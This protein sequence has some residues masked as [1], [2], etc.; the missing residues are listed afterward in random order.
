MTGPGHFLDRTDAVGVALR[1]LVLTR[2]DLRLVE[3]P[4]YL[5]TD[6]T[7]PQRRVGLVSGGG[8]GHEPMHG[9]FVGEGGLDAAA[10]GLVFASPHNS[11]VLEASRAA[12]REAGVLQIVKN[13]T[14]DVINFGI[15]AERLRA[16]GVPVARVL[17]ADD[18]ASGGADTE[19][20]R[21]GTGA[22]VIVERA[23]ATAADRGDGLDELAELG[24]RVVAASRSLAVASRAQTSLSTGAP[25]FDLEDGHL[26]YGVGIHGERAATST[27]A[28]PL[29]DL[30]SRMT[31][32][33]SDA[34]R[35]TAAPDGWSLFVNGLGS[36]IELEL[37]TVLEMAVA[38]LAERGVTVTATLVGTYVAAL[39]MRGFSLTLTALDSG[40]HEL[41]TTGGGGSGLPVLTPVTTSAIESGEPT[42]AGARTAPADDPFLVAI[43]HEAERLHGGLTRLDQLAGDGDFGDNLLAG[44]RGAA[45]QAPA[46]DSPLP[47]LSAAVVEFLD[48]VG[49]SS[50]PLYGLFL[51]HVHDA[52]AAV[53]PG[54][55]EAAL[56]DAVRRGCAD[57]QT[58]ITRIAGA[59]P[60]DRTM[61]DTL[62]AV[63]GS[64]ATTL[65]DL[66]ADALAGATSTAAMTARRGR[67]SYVG[68]R[69]LGEPDPGAVGVVVV[70][71]SVA[72]A[73]LPGA[74]A[75]DLLDG[76]A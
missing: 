23:L 3:R 73:V 59:E 69:V 2:P 15:A 74:V 70:L 22:T 41:L 21:R 64:S 33:L 34:L 57:A 42:A 11:Q 67:A 29:E 54:A 24:T 14:G 63:A 37:L 46:P 38:S 25:A 43:I 8:S 76:W 48:E 75:R 7:R 66:L 31:G 39:D 36:V 27:P 65:G 60:G 55:D 44:A 16:E 5:T 52:V 1:G 19:T 51:Q 62:A 68:E 45:R 30:V 72:E 71:A 53:L 61:V 6:A 17:V 28:P 49:G 18:L 58:T 47:G 10:P 20:G 9:G 4:R 50:G 56:T 35:G 40:W 32:E 13:Y 26:E 12:A